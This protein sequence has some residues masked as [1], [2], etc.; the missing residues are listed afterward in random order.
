[1]TSQVTLVV[2]N[3]SVLFENYLHY[4]FLRIKRFFAHKSAFPRCLHVTFFFFLTSHTV[5]PDS[6]SAYWARCF[7]KAQEV[8][9]MHWVGLTITGSEER[10]PMW[11][12]SRGHYSS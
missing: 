1:M 12:D 6:S 2:K 11:Y 5:M 4:Q 3:P 10:L 7:W 9:S 8:R